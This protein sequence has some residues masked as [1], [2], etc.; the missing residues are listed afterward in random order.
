MEDYRKED[1]KIDWQAYRQAEIDIGE[2]CYKCGEFILLFTRENKTQSLCGAC[3][4]LLKN[5]EVSHH[6][7]VR[8]PKCQD[9]T[10]VFGSER[11]E[12]YQEGEH[13]VSCSECDC[14]FEVRTDVE[15]KFT[16]PKVIP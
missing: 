9:I 7:Y 11:Y 16:S 3:I 12:L 1:G 5:D 13:E 8:C 4:D 2:R 15:Y 10:N 14:D 6:S